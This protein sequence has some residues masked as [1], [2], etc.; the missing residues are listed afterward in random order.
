MAGRSL[1]E[2]I[3]RE[4]LAEGREADAL[5]DD[6]RSRVSS[7]LDALPTGDRLCHGEPP[8]GRRIVLAGYLR[9]Y[10]AARPVDL[11]LLA[12]WQVVCAAA[13]LRGPVPEDHPAVL[14]YLRGHIDGVT[15]G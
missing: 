14:A 12:R 9:A 13:R 7:L 8:V 6:L 3:E 15:R 5:P 1:D 2:V 11:A 4:L 10:R